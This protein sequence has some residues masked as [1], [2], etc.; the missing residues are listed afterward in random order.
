MAEENVEILRRIY[1][2]WEAGDFTL[3]ADAFDPQ[4]VFF[5]T[6]DELS[7]LGLA[8]KWRGLAEVGEALREWLR[9]WEN[10][11]IEAQ[12]FRDLGERVLVLDRHIATG[13]RS[14]VP[15]DHEMGQVVT[16][17]EGRI[18]RWDAYWNRPEALEAAGLTE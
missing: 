17:R 3:Q 10:L 11:R 4:I 18:V 6:G 12:E 15:L 14:G 8:G 5:R 16:V 9:A 1:T 13:K 7:G 2:A